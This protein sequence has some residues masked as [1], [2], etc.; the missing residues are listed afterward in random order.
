M[1][2]KGLTTVFDASVPEPSNAARVDFSLAVAATIGELRE[3]ERQ[4]AEAMRAALDGHGTTH[5]TEQVE[6]AIRARA[7]A[8]FALQAA[9]SRAQIDALTEKMIGQYRELLSNPLK[10]FVQ[11]RG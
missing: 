6:E 1:E 5:T 3:H 10:L 9:T 2:L 8:G 7:E 4:A 11:G